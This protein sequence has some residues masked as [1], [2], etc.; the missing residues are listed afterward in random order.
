LHGNIRV[1]LQFAKK[2]LLQCSSNPAS[3]F[4]TTILAATRDVEV[5]SVGWWRIGDSY[6]Y[7]LLTVS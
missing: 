4:Y 1:N 7:Q 2:P 6:Y 5:F 3:G